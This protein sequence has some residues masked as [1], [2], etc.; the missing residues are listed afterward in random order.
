MA[1]SILGFVLLANMEFGV[2]EAAGL[3]V[4]WLLQ[5]VRP[6]IREEIT[7]LYFA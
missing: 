6:D 1:Q 4:L 5:F 2:F 3:F 7:I